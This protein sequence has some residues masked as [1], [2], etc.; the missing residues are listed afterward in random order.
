MINAS[1]F[2][3]GA[4]TLLNS[5]P[6]EIL[7][8][9]S[10]GLCIPVLLHYDPYAADSHTR[11]SFFPPPPPARGFIASYRQ[12]S[13]EPSLLRRSLRVKACSQSPHP[14]VRAPSQQGQGQ[15][16][17]S[18][19]LRP[20]LCALCWRRPADELPRWHRPTRVSA[21]YR[22]NYINDNECPY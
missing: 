1:F 21:L 14:R 9:N 6:T 13:V 19:D 16:H 18:S 4:T 11:R 7:H 15:G 3:G 2:V 10:I 20:A 5:A 22:G 17:G 12:E 8:S